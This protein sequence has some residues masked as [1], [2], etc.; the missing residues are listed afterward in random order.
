M[1]LRDIIIPAL[2]DVWGPLSGR[3]LG[4]CHDI[5]CNTLPYDFARLGLP[6]RPDSGGA[7]RTRGGFGQ[8]MEIAGKDDLEFA[9]NAIFDR[10]T[11]APKGRDGG[12]A[13][14]NGNVALKSGRQLRPKGFQVVPNGDRLVLHMPGGGGMGDPTERD[15]GLVARDVRDG[16]ISPQAARKIYQVACSAAGVLDAETTRQLRAGEPT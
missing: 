5:A 9:C 6:P 13:G 3:P 1:S 14:A 4:P 8:I 12:L 15:P 2:P 10:V 16:V 7:G 11:F